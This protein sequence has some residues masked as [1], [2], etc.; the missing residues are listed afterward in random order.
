MMAQRSEGNGTSRPRV[1]SDPNLLKAS[2]ALKPEKLFEYKL[3]VEDLFKRHGPTKSVITL[4]A[5]E[6]AR[7]P[8]FAGIDPDTWDARF[9]I[10]AHLVFNE[11]PN[12]LR[13][14]DRRGVADPCMELLRT[15]AYHEM[16]HWELPRGSGFGCP[17]DKVAYYTSFIEPIHGKLK[18]ANKF[19]DDF[20]KSMSANLA[21]AVMDVIDNYNMANLLAQSDE[22]PT[23]Q[24]LFWYLQGQHCGD[25]GAEYTLF[26]MHNLGLFGDKDDT[27][28]LRKFF[29]RDEKLPESLGK[30]REAF[31]T[32][33][34]YDRAQW[35]NLAAL[36]AEEALKYITPQDK[37]RHKRSADDKSS[38]GKKG[39]PSKGKGKEESGAG[40]EQG[41]E[42]GQGDGKQEGKGGKN[43]EGGE[44]EE[45]DGEGGEQKGKAGKKES[46]KEGKG[47]QSGEDEQDGE[48]EG[49]GAGNAGKKESDKKGKADGSEED[50][51]QGG[52]QEGK[53]AGKAGKKESDKKGKGGQS[54]EDEQDGAG[55]G[56]GKPGAEGEE[57][58]ED[59]EGP[60]DPE[61]EGDKKV[62]FGGVPIGGDLTPDD[63]EKIMGGRMGGRTAGPA[64]VPFYIKGDEALDAYYRLLAK[65]IPLKLKGSAPGRNF[66]VLPL[67]HE[68]FDPDVHSIEDAVAARLHVDPLSRS[69]IPSVLKI[70]WPVQV[71]IKKEKGELPDFVFSLIDSS[72]SM[73]QKGDRSL[74]PWGNESYY[75]Y[76]LWTFWGLLR[77]FESERILHKIDVSAAIFSSATLDTKG[78]AEVKRML[79]NPATGGTTIDL[80]TV[81]KNLQG[82]KNPMF[83]M[84]S[85][86]DI[87]NWNTVKDR[88]IEA[89][90][91]SQFFMIEI[92][93]HGSKPSQTSKDL[94][95]AK[96]LVKHVTSASEIVNLAIDLTAN[97]YRAIMHEYLEREGAKFTRLR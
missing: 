79:L 41:K 76:A 94:E 89:A 10:D 12:L 86:G 90:K 44:K 50:E 1:R 87:G 20:C 17:Y 23:G 64:G 42:G 54:G 37:P 67:V 65:R 45:E 72:G 60:G 74:V 62:G 31:T 28:L 56:S 15:T 6:H 8:L 11:D 39:K 78:L 82:R 18:S 52:E 5:R 24:M 80:D 19:S 69:F 58:D 27:G 63:I 55:A 66:P 14:M 49:K 68:R 25:Y 57:E 81:L 2:L 84:I 51:G 97:R 9:V 83:S 22:R 92:N 21:N 30:L 77:F 75:H 13:F 95:E 40:G 35:A 48:Q 33:A 47:G 61:E 34:I 91:R 7:T 71:P 88:F 16:G 29:S 3:M 93:E 46:G 70:R 85:D 59:A 36:Y 43:G 4:E 53:G 73:M 32:A 26:V 38:S 96:F